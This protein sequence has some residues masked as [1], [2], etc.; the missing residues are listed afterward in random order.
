MA[1]HFGSLTIISWLGSAYL[2]ALAAVQPLS[3]KLTDIFGRR[4]GLLLCSI[5]FAVEN[6]MCAVA[7]SKSVIIS[8]RVVAGIG[9]GGLNSI[10]TFL[11]TDLIPLR[12]RGMWQGIGMVVFGA[13]IGLGGVVGG[14]INDIW[15][16]RYAF[17]LLTP[18]TAIS[19]VGVWFFVP[20]CIQDEGSSSLD[21]VR[22]I[23]FPGACLLVLTLAL[24]LWS[25][26][27]EKDNGSPSNL[28]LMISLPIVVGLLILFVWVEA[29]YVLEPI[30]PINLLRVRT[31]AASC[32]TSGFVGMGMY[33]LMFYVPLY[34]QIRGY[35]T[36][37][38][39]LRLL[40]EACGTAL[41]C[42]G[43]GMITRLT[44]GY[45]RLKVVALHL[46]VGGAIGFSTSTLT[47]TVVLPEIYLFVNG[48]GFGGTLTVML[49]S[50]LSAVE[51]EAQATATA[52]LYAFRTIGATVGTTASNI[53][54]REVLASRLS[55]QLHLHSVEQML[56]DC[57][58][59]ARGQSKCPH[60]VR[61]GFMRA[62]QA[63]FLLSLGFAVACLTSGL[64][65]QNFRLRST[66][67]RK[68]KHDNDT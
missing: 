36:G 50:L 8:G 2:I 62:L 28:V 33:T 9:A 67:D 16:W 48:L 31:V 4:S 23:D 13:G 44:G 19:A 59:P 43:S 25:L 5:L 57:N 54:F 32:L 51:R 41:G 14:A 20:D 40:P 22:R 27:Y 7:Q 63:V 1:S 39:G 26:N 30:I 38:V 6:L 58:G 68:A 66:L 11:A 12:K 56:K 21:R 42:L 3:G 53:F 55:S 15:G 46:F 10:C 18:L 64:F 47:T 34:L 45:G 17:L 49:L 24:L 29:R 52:M 65:T 61:E 37:E 60:D 35:R